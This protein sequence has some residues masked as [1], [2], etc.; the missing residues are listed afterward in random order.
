[1]AEGRR[2]KIEFTAAKAL[3]KTM[4]VEE[5]CKNV[6]RA[7][8][9]GPPQFLLTLGYVPQKVWWTSS[10]FS[11]GLEKLGFCGVTKGVFKVLFSV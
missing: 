10:L 5:I 9:I 11:G 8:G 7:Y 1:M 6:I 3:A 4:S 2:R